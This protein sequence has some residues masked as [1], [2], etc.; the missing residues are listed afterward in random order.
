LH[1]IGHSFS[2]CAPLGK[3][4]QILDLIL[5]RAESD[6][7]L[8]NAIPRVAMLEGLP[9]CGANLLAADVVWN[10]STRANFQRIVWIEAGSRPQRTALEL[11]NQIVEATMQKPTLFG[12]LEEAG[13]FIKSV[14][15]EYELMTNSLLLV[16]QNCNDRTVLD[17]MLSCLS[18][19]STVLVTSSSSQ[20]ALT[21]VN[22]PQFTTI[23]ISMLQTEEEC[24]RGVQSVRFLPE[25]SLSTDSTP[26]KRVIQLSKDCFYS[27]EAILEACNLI[28]TGMIMN[29]SDSEWETAYSAVKESSKN[30]IG[31]LEKSIEV[32]LMGQWDQDMVEAYRDLVAFPFNQQ[33]PVAVLTVQW[34]TLKR[35]S[36]VRFSHFP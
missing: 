20:V 2:F 15:G 7:A 32:D 16:L 28:P 9:G 14:K 30:F 5:K 6:G 29:G 25:N 18:Q 34:F 23:K 8:I 22:A 13:A 36:Y 4:T 26:F 27:P 31:I 12:T 3:E 10:R 1:L 33:I 19:K 35:F 11:L 24:I 17:D 21:H